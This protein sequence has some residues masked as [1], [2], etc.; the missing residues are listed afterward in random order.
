VDDEIALVGDTLFGVLPRS[1]WPPF[2]DD[3]ARMVQ[4]WG[5]LLETP[6]RLFL[7]GHGREIGRERLGRNFAARNN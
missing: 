3:P 2:A 4:S 5:Q 6:C 7:P 1:V